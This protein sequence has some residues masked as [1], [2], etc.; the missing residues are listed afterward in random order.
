[1]RLSCTQ[2]L[3]SGWYFIS[4]GNL[5]LWEGLLELNEN[6]MVP[7]IEEGS[8]DMKP[9]AKIRM[10][11]EMMITKEYRGRQNDMMMK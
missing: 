9:K 6:V 5:K 8:K 3:T 1:M 11:S 4:P 10:K 2:H 7:N